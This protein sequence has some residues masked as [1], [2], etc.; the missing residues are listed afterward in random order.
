MLGM[1]LLCYFGRHTPSM[2]SISHGK[3]GGYAA[4]CEACAVPLERAD[5]RPW[6]AADPKYAHIDRPR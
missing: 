4:L 6:R 2:Q 5:N 3:H 1:S